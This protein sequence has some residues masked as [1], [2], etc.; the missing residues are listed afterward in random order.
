MTKKISSDGKQASHSKFPARR[1]EIKRARAAVFAGSVE[2]QSALDSVRGTGERL[3]TY[4]PR[5]D[6]WFRADLKRELS[7]RLKDSVEAGEIL[8]MQLAYRAE[9]GPVTAID[10]FNCKDGARLARHARKGCQHA[11]VQIVPVCLPSATGTGFSIASVV[12]VLA[13]ETRSSSDAST[14]RAQL[15][16]DGLSTRL[17]LTSLTRSNPADGDVQDVID[18]FMSAPL[19]IRS[20]ANRLG[21]VSEHQGWAES[22]DA[23]RMLT[24]Y[25][26]LLL[27]LPKAFWGVG[28]GEEILRHGATGATMRAKQAKKREDAIDLNEM[29]DMLWR[30]ALATGGTRPPLVRF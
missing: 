1:A 22:R 20:K 12:T 17:G 23:R 18:A 21:R 7:R 5:A 26:D 10:A 24:A 19:D 28:R 15:K 8:N 29:T 4:V 3:L 30:H 11:L 14:P 13:F 2:L 27:P 25:L 9:T 6:D 16:S